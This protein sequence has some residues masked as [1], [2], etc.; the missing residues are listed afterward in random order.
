M[1]INK[2]ST[3]DDISNFI[4]SFIKS[5][6]V[7]SKFREEKIKGNEIFFFEKNEFKKL[8]IL[9]FINI[10][11]K[12]NEIINNKKDILNFNETVNENY[13]EEKIASFL[14]NEMKLE[15]SVLNNFRNIDG[16]KFITIKNE[17]LINFGLKLGERKKLSKYLESIREYNITNLS[18]SEEVCIFLKINLI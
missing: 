13:T 6:K 18:S 16:E 4:K 3:I 5:E 8:G 12:L 7:I 2:D 1:S 17:D 15:E 11:D 10:K 14:K 9:N